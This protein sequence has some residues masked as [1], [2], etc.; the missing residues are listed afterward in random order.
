MAHVPAPVTMDANATRPP[1][2]IPTMLDR[3]LNSEVT[4][5]VIWSAFAF[6]AIMSVAVLALF[7]IR[8]EIRKNRK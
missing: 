8:A 4:V 6:V 3:I 1:R 7:R 5:F 2:E